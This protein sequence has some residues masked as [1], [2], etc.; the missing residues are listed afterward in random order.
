MRSEGKSGSHA[1]FRHGVLILKRILGM[2]AQADG[3]IEAGSEGVSVDTHPPCQRNDERLQSATPGVRT[4][5]S[6]ARG[7][8]RIKP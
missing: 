6:N 5:A 2:N 3:S 7:Q 4:T 8:I 1:Q